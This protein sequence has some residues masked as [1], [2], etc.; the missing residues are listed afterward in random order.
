MA[1]PEDF[2]RSAVAAVGQ[3]G[4]PKEAIHFEAYAF[5]WPTLC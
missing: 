5:E 1:G 2:V 4:V 3:F